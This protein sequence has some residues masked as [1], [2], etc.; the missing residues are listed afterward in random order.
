MV[1]DSRR[2]CVRATLRQLAFDPGSASEQR[3]AIGRGEQC[4]PRG[5]GSFAAP[6]EDTADA[7]S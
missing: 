6:G 3:R 1:G 4:S 7:N 2:P 5:I